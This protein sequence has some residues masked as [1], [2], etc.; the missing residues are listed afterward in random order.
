MPRLYHNREWFEEIS[1]SALAEAE[2]E[3]LLIQNVE[4]IQ[5]DAL[6]IPFKKTVYSSEDSARADLALISGDFRHWVVVEVEMSRHDLYSHVIPQVRTLR[7]ANYTQDYVDYI[8]SKCPEL[9]RNLL[10]SLMRGDPPDVLV[11]VNKRDVE[12]EKEMNRY[13]AHLMAIEIYRSN[14]NKTILVVDGQPPAISH[15][16]LSELTFAMLPRCLLVKSPGALRVEPGVRFPISVDGQIT[17]W[18]RFHT[19]TGDYLTPVG[20]LPITPK[21]RYAL[22]QS[23]DCEYAIRPIYTKGG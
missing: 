8:H 23:E 6:I 19:S 2:F 16:F 1:P 13:G 15:S 18:E 10:S 11:I 4:V 5:R 22:V 12:W 20:S 7:E 17:Y 9:N 21:G 3:E 14:L